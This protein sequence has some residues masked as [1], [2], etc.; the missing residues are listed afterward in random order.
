[1]HILWNSKIHIIVV[2][3]FFFII[4]IIKII[5]INFYKKNSL[6]YIYTVI[7]LGFFSEKPT[8]TEVKNGTIIMQTVL[9]SRDM[10]P[11]HTHSLIYAIIGLSVA[12]VLITIIYIYTYKLE[13]RNIIT[14]TV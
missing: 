3:F 5:V 10:V 1:M 8:D 12:A 11:H 7:Y 13:K 4:F 6:N 14:R 2:G 9:A